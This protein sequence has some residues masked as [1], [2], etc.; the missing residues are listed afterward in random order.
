[1][2]LLAKK[3]KKKRLVL[4]HSYW[5][6]QHAHRLCL[7]T[8]LSV[9]WRKWVER[10]KSQE[11]FPWSCRH[12]GGSKR[13]QASSGTG[14]ESPDKKRPPLGGGCGQQMEGPPATRKLGP[15]CG[16]CL[17]GRFCRKSPREISAKFQ[18]TQGVWAA[19]GLSWSTAIHRPADL[20]L[21]LARRLL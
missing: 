18:Q 6:R 15:A 13:S 20:S 3:K 11:E 21:T 5:E 4:L 9:K 8:F 12:R 1:M 10:R 2:S 16:W 19:F 7:R 14:A 17:A